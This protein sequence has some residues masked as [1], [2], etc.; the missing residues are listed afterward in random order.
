MSSVTPTTVIVHSS[1]E[2]PFAETEAATSASSLTASTFLSQSFSAQGGAL[3]RNVHGKS[4]VWQFFKVYDETKFK[5][6]A[7]VYYVNAMLIMVEL[8]LDED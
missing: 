2:S 3:K 7:F 6:H 8:I 4:E 5:T 1:P